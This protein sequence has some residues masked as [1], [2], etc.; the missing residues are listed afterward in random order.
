VNALAASELRKTSLGRDFMGNHYWLQKDIHGGVR[1][2]RED[3]E[4]E[5]WALVARYVH[6]LKLQILAWH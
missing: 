3:P 1:I 2:Y 4:E 5:T 6:Y